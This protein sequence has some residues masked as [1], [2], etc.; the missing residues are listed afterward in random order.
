MELSLTSQPVEIQCWVVPL[1]CA[2]ARS[3]NVLVPVTQRKLKGRS[4]APVG[5][6]EQFKQIMPGRAHSNKTDQI[7]SK[8]CFALRM[9]N[10][11]G[12]KEGGLTGRQWS[13]ERSGGS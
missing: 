9:Q 1:E 6:T 2:L 13:G 8:I 11:G 7:V 3:E 10:G 12:P 4:T 5:E